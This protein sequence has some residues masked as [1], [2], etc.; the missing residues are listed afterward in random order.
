MYCLGVMLGT[1]F[2]LLGAVLPTLI[3]ADK[4][5]KEALDANGS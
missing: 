4:A 1:A 5:V 2:I 3:Q